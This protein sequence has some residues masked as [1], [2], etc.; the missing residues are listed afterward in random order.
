[1]TI[2]DEQNNGRHQ[3]ALGGSAVIEDSALSVIFDGRN[4][5]EHGGK[6][7]G[8]IRRR[9]SLNIDIVG[10]PT[11]NIK[12]GIEMPCRGQKYA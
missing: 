2:S 4:K 9:Q 1:M 6:R 11:S 7:R 3:N 12:K 5:D 8:Q 10:I